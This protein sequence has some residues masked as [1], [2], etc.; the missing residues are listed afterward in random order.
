[1]NNDRKAGRSRARN[2]LWILLVF[3]GISASA[4]AGASASALSAGQ[5]LSHLSLVGSVFVLP[6][7]ITVAVLAIRQ[8]AHAIGVGWCLMMIGSGILVGNWLAAASPGLLNAVLAALR[9]TVT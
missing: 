5:S 6:A 3:V 4:I 7:V 2:Q 9:A 8:V 1:M